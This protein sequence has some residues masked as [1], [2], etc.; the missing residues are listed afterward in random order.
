[1]QSRNCFIFTLLSLI[2]LILMISIYFETLILAFV[3]GVSEFIPVSSSAHLILI[4]KLS[5]FKANI[6]EIDIGLHFG[7]LLAIIFYFKDDLKNILKNKNLSLL[8]VL[9]SIPLII[10]GFIVYQTGMIHLLRD[11]KVIAW[12]TLLF[13]ILLFYADKFQFNKD[14]KKDLNIKNIL[15]IGFFQML[16]V[17]PGVSR[18]GITIT[19]A[20]LL[21]F[22]RFDSTKI[23]FLLSI[24]ALIGASFLGLKDISISNFELSS[25]VILS[26]IFSFVFS[27]LTIKYFLIYVKKFSLK[28]FVYYRVILA[29][30]LFSF[31][32]I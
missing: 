9:G 29:L 25:S 13:G 31:I 28:L 4:S 22:N 21:N 14:I 12:T 17:I 15:I 18:S 5:K 32:Y 10:F 8:I 7:S 30:L 20:R 6:L 3:Q 26:A 1:M 19:A 24:P 27:Y 16:A 2:N 23:S 11:I